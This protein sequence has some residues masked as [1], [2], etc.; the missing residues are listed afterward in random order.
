MAPGRARG[1]LLG[2]SEREDELATLR[3]MVKRLE[4]GSMIWS[5]ARA[6]PAE[7]AADSHRQAE[8]LKREIAYLERVL[9]RAQGT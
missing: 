2:M 5:R 4:D 7:A 1:Y 8:L 6:S 3:Q 9:A